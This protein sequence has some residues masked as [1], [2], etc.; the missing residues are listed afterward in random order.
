[1]G[2]DHNRCAFVMVIFL[3]HRV[4][5]I[6]SLFNK[7]PDEIRAE[8]EKRQLLDNLVNQFLELWR[9]ELESKGGR[10]RQKARLAVVDCLLPEPGRQR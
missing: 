2:L 6:V 1:M 7:I 8:A 9:V 3:P 5:G 10:R 4:E